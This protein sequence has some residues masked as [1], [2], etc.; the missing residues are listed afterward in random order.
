MGVGDSDSLL[1]VDRKPVTRLGGVY[2]LELSVLCAPIDEWAGQRLTGRALSGILDTGAETSCALSRR[3][4]ETH[5]DWGPVDRLL[6]TRQVYRG[7]GGIPL[8]T[9]SGHCGL[10]LLPEGREP[11]IEQPIRV[12]RLREV[13]VVIPSPETQWDRILVGIH[14]LRAM[15]ANL[16]VEFD[17]D[18]F[19]IR[20]PRSVVQQSA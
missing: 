14:A 19:S 7:V 6:N 9:K 2:R 13:V 1:L 10:W 17:S 11:E 8:V 3:I 5:F 12:P 15:R 20:V 16:E 4:Y 18:V